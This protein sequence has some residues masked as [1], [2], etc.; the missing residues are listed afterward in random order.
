MTATILDFA[1]ARISR[2]LPTAHRFR[3]GDA[4]WIVSDEHPRNIPGTVYGHD[5]IAD[6]YHVIPLSGPAGGR[7]VAATNLKPRPV[8]WRDPSLCNHTPEGAA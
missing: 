4:V 7:Y 5:A 6:R 2:G 8:V 1:A 3:R